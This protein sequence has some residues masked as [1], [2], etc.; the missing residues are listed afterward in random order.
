MRPSASTA[1]LAPLHAVPDQSIVNLAIDLSDLEGTNI[2]LG[3]AEVI[4]GRDPAST[5]QS[6]VT[7]LQ[8]GCHATVMPLDGRDN[9]EVV[10]VRDVLS[11]VVVGLNASAKANTSTVK[12]GLIWRRTDGL[13][14]DLL[15]E[16][17]RDM[18]PSWAGRKDSWMSQASQKSQ[19]STIGRPDSSRAKPRAIVSVCDQGELDGV[20]DECL[21]NETINQ[22]CVI[23][24][25]FHDEDNCLFSMLHVAVARTRLS[26]LNLANMVKEIGQ[27]HSVGHA[28]DYPL[29]SA[30][31]TEL[32]RL[33]ANYLRGDAK[34]FVVAHGEDNSYVSSIV[35]VCASSQTVWT[36]LVWLDAS[37]V[38]RAA[39]VMSWEALGAR[40]DDTDDNEGDT[41]DDLDGVDDSDNEVTVYEVDTTVSDI[42]IMAPFGGD[43]A[44]DGYASHRPNGHN[45]DGRDPDDSLASCFQSP[46][47][48]SIRQSL[49]EHIAREMSTAAKRAALTIDEDSPTGVSPAPPTGLSDKSGKSYTERRLLFSS[50][51]QSQ[52]GGGEVLPAPASADAARGGDKAVGCNAQS[53]LDQRS[54]DFFSSLRT[55]DIECKFDDT[56]PNIES[57]SLQRPTTTDELG[58]EFGRSNVD[59]LEAAKTSSGGASAIA[60]TSTFTTTTDNNDNANDNANDSKTTS[61]QTY[62]AVFKN[63][64]ARVNERFDARLKDLTE[65]LEISEMRRIELQSSY[66]V[67]KDG[68]AAGW[69]FSD[70]QS[71]IKSLQEEIKRSKSLQATVSSMEQERLE[72]EVE[73]DAKDR[74]I[75]LLRA[76]VHS[77]ESDSD[78]ST[79]YN[80]AEEAL[81]MSQ[82]ECRLLRQQNADLVAK[83]ADMEVS[84]LMAA[85]G[86]SAILPEDEDYDV[87]AE[88][89]IIYKLHEKLKRAERRGKRLET[90]NAELRSA[91]QDAKKSQRVALVTKNVCEKLKKKVNA[92]QRELQETKRGAGC[93]QLGRRCGGVSA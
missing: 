70:H 37:I 86:V 75:G 65:R 76:R 32:N 13:D 77:L 16:Y 3:E 58:V 79:A 19:L 22:D 9:D 61:A 63:I 78:V 66:E 64:E 60:A 41:A 43:N 72:A 68:P 1:N 87:D 55:I 26:F 85:N 11:R 6:L 36:D 47:I 38:R 69:D 18:E 14:V 24:I 28:G 62:N 57:I 46:S 88:A 34:L 73:N 8:K 42:P 81:T 20:L 21:M 91:L 2:H 12:T 84:S 45:A 29:K 48:A 15:E 31:M 50:L 4:A 7:W 59:E 82:E 39:S 89:R 44:C 35:S 54:R 49:Q 40:T 25:V 52:T 90:E 93:A 27:M 74:E 5:A 23:S 53:H 33:A 83:L 71:L 92:L 10:W 67:L 17:K 30:N 51:R 80:L 56:D